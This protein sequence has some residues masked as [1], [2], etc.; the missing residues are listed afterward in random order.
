[1]RIK[2]EAIV[3]KNANAPF[4][5]YKA[6]NIINGKFYVGVTKNGLIARSKAHLDDAIRK[7]GNCWKFHN[8]I[9]KHGVDSFYW[10]V[11]E[12]PSSFEEMMRREFE[13]IKQLKPEYN[14][15]YGG[16]GAPGAMLGKKHTDETK[17]RLREY[18]LANI[19]L[20]KK[21]QHLGPNSLK[22]KVVCLNTGEI[23]ESTVVAARE[24]K[25]NQICLLSI[26]N[27]HHH[28]KAVG[29]LVFRYFGDHFGG[30]E[31]ANEILRQK[32]SRWRSV[33]C[34]TD[35]LEFESIAA[36][37]RFYGTSGSLIE[38]SC[39]KGYFITKRKLKF[40]YT[41]SDEVIRFVDT[42]AG[43]L[44]RKIRAAKACLAAKNA[45]AARRANGS[46]YA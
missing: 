43:K 41:N 12:T 21:Y 22:K 19:D 9:R 31:E 42:E 38:A 10:E 4:L 45:A 44:D 34:I 8:A 25:V 18:G 13:L 16:R 14:I 5:V 24:K 6:T 28:R 39:S 7:T 1:M 11:L 36:A 27:R 35:K 3:S 26:C 32:K 37:T 20:F 23:F 17:K 30:K 29:G 15:C 2:V 46:V 40:R 33:F